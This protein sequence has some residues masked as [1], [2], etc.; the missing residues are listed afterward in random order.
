MLPLPRTLHKIV[1]T[2]LVGI[3][4]YALT[5]LTN[6]PPIWSL[7]ITVFIGGI[8]FVVQFLIE[9]EQR[10]QESAHEG[11]LLHDAVRLEVSKLG[12]ASELYGLIATSALS[13]RAITEL[14][15]QTANVDRQTPPLVRIL[16][17]SEVARAA[18]VL[19]DL[20]ATGQMTYEGEDRDWLLSLTEHMTTELCATSVF[21]DGSFWLSELGQRYIDLQVQAVRRG[22]QIRRVFV[23]Q[24]GA[25]G[26]MLPTSLVNE[27]LALGFRVRVLDGPAVAIPDLIIV[28]GVVIYETTPQQRVDQIRP[29]RFRTAMQTRPSIVAERLEWFEHLWSRAKA[30]G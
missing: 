4:A 6:Q 30:P 27:Q 20:N 10:L 14:V 22:A 12:K 1:V 15:E 19:K 18:Q 2:A 24:R 17:E 29:Y 16:V 25:R 26:G 23:N 7:T 28:D 8:T 11:K 5:E 9:V 13:S 21:H 3:I